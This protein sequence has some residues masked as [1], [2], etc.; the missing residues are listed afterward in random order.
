MAGETVFANLNY[1]TTDNGQGGVEVDG[2]LPQYHSIDHN[3]P[4]IDRRT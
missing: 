4:S 2:D 3:R 1:T